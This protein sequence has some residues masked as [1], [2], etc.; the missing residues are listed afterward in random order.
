MSVTNRN[1]QKG[2]NTLTIKQKSTLECRNEKTIIPLLIRRT[3]CLLSSFTK[4]V[5]MLYFISVSPQ[6][7]Y[8]I[9]R[10]AI[11]MLQQVSLSAGYCT[12]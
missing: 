6:A 2:E 11:S 4:L 5:R 10:G 7:T 8:G 9:G 12:Q 1:F 3:N